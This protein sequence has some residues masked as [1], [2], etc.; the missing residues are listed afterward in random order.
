MQVKTVKMSK[1][2]LKQLLE[3][4]KIT[5]ERSRRKMMENNVQVMESRVK[6]NFSS[7]QT[8]KPSKLEQNLALASNC[9]G[10][11]SKLASSKPNRIPS[12]LVLEQQKSP[13]PWAVTS[14]SLNEN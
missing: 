6:R 12:F 5:I 2:E 10:T 14:M 11:T 3:T 13:L 7:R 1:T 8:N 4:R 9:L